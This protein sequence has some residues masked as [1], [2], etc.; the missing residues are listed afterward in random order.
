MTTAIPLSG[1]SADVQ[2]AE[3]ALQGI[4][5]DVQ[6]LQA[7]NLCLRSS[8]GNVKLQLIQSNVNLKESYVHNKKLEKTVQDLRAD[9]AAAKV[10]RMR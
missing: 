4:A 3:Q 9:L 2:A 1:T 10:S 6:A 7:E 5:A 8:L